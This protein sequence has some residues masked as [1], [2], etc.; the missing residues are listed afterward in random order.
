M[1]TG[2]LLFWNGMRRAHTLT[3]GNFFAIAQPSQAS[4][5]ASQLGLWLALYLVFFI[6]S[7]FIGL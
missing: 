1:V 7:I 4:K 3:D 5:S 6:A 2:L